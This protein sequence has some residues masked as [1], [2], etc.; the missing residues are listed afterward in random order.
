MKKGGVWE[1]RRQTDTLHAGQS[2]RGR[3]TAG[4]VG[5]FGE[6]AAEVMARPTHGQGPVLSTLMA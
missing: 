3:Q 6:L 2:H 1:P 4:G 5:M